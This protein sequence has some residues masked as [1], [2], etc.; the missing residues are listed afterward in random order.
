[1]RPGNFDLVDTRAMINI[2]IV[3]NLATRFA[4]T[5]TNSDGYHENTLREMDLG[6][7]ATIGF[8][9][10]L[11]WTPTETITVDV[12]GQWNRNQL[13][14][15]AERCVV[16]AGGSALIAPP[17]FL[18]ACRRSRPFHGQHDEHE[19]T[20]Q[21]S[22]GAWG[23]IDWD[24]SDLAPVDD[25]YLKSISS[26]RGGNLRFRGDIDATELPV[27]KLAAVGPA[28][29]DGG[30]S[31]GETF[32]QELQLGGRAF[33]DRL[34]FIV[35]AFGFW[36]KARLP[37]A[38]LF[39]LAGLPQ[40]GITT[41]DTDNWDWAMF[42]QAT[43]DITDWLSFTAGVRYTQEKKGAGLA[44]QTLRPEVE[45]PAPVLMGREVFD[46]W[47][48]MASVA[49][50]LPEDWV[51]ETPIDH[52]MTYFTYSRGFRGGGFNSAP[53]TEESGVDLEPFDPE[54]LDSFEVG[55]KSLAFEDRFSANLAL[56]YYDWQD[57]QVQTTELTSDGGLIQPIRNAAAATGQGVELELRAIPMPGL[58]LTGSI[59]YVEAEYDKFDSV[60]DL[61]FNLRV[62]RAGE[63]LNN[64]PELQTNLA[65][66]FSLPVEPGSF[67]PLFGYLT[68]RVQWYYQSNEQYAGPELRE[69]TQPGYNLLNAR[70][71]YTFLDGRAQ[72]ALWGKNLTDE[73]YF[74]NAQPL[75]STFGHVLRTYNLPRTYG[76]Q[77]SY[78]FGGSG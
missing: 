40:G 6:G 45:D 49:L 16:A 58:L 28:Q 22:W 47:T 57:V 55:L 37:Q 48:P 19:L 15:N 8:L 77:I 31:D 33:D 29:E 25:L 18:D 13:R 2:P 36:E 56:F 78:R 74:S 30:E 1:M 61:V 4:L 26:W 32:M 71:N 59:G 21:E 5:T 75:A 20:D 24:I 63:R 72:V 73:V 62:D 10:S 44:G 68:P 66:Q 23:V 70:L 38:T 60:S 17:G 46:S 67:E 34:K 35:G 53:N 7:T 76:A 9:G 54:T 64:T 12:S 41:S 52:L 65:V 42:T 69:A 43:G 50:T 27:V 3:D 14:G 11:R 51:D 39:S